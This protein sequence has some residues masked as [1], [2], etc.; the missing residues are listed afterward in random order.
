MN[1]LELK[2]PPVVLVLVTVSGMWAVS[3]GVPVFRFTVSGAVWL[4]SSIALLGVL[5]A[6][7]GVLA[8]KNAGTT[9]DPRVPEQ[10]ENLV[11]SGVYRFSRNPMYLGFLLTLLG[12]GLY[13]GSF[14]AL[15]FLPAFIAYMNRFQ[16]IPEERFM[17]ARFGDSYARYRAKVRRW[18]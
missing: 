7:L 5:V 2:V 6:I 11:V 3:A 12:W 14:A 17:R 4:S 8:F 16:I 18:V 15:F 9:V 13:L 1:A 10:S